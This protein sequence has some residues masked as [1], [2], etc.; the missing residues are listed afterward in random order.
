LLDQRFEFGK[1]LDLQRIVGDEPGD[2]VLFGGDC[3]QRAAIAILERRFAGEQVIALTRFDGKDAAIELPQRYAHLL[4][5]AD[6]CHRIRVTHDRLINIGAD[7][8]QQQHGAQ[9]T[10]EHFPLDGAADQPSRRGVAA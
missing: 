3:R 4:G 2:F 6:P 9:E 7:A 10:G 5:V 1:A 8:D